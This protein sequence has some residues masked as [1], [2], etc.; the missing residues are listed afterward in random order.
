MSLQDATQVL[1]EAS[2]VERLI[3]GGLTFDVIGSFIDGSDANWAKLF[4]SPSRESPP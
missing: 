2:R 1:L 4:P 3:R